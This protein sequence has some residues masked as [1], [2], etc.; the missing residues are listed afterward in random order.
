M[1]S[2]FRSRLTEIPEVWSREEVRVS[3]S[4]RNLS[5]SSVKANLDRMA[6]AVQRY[7]GEY[8]EG[9]KN[10]D[11]EG[12]CRL[13]GAVA[14]IYLKNTEGKVS[15]EIQEEYKRLVKAADELNQQPKPE[16]R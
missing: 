8:K 11:I 4:L 13:Y 12:L 9:P 16:L 6:S 7:L 14:R 2:E 3:K 10:V 1:V 5:A 15:A